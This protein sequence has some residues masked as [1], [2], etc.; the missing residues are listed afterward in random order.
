VCGPTT[1]RRSQESHAVAVAR[2]FP[3]I[4]RSRGP[5]APQAPREARGLDAVTRPWHPSFPLAPTPHPEGPKVILP[6]PA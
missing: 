4:A 6:T 3:A 1:R 2:N 5:G